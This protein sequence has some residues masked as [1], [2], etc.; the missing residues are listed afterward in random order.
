MSWVWLMNNL[1]N[2]K[3]YTWINVYLNYAFYRVSKEHAFLLDLF[4]IGEDDKLKKKHAHHEP[5]L[6]KHSEKSDTNHSLRNKYFVL[7]KT[8][9]YWVINS[10]NH[11]KDKGCKSPFKEWNDDD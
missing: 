5:N 8:E 7:D 10:V 4:L 2:G 9:T 6:H 11:A 1:T 3:V